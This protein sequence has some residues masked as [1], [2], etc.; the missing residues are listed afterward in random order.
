MVIKE[1]HIANAIKDSD[2]RNVKIEYDVILQDI[3]RSVIE[4]ST[5]LFCNLLLIHSL[6]N[7]YK[8]Q[9]LVRL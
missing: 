7:A 6:K 9:F 1:W 3:I 4:N 2:A 8:H 5:E